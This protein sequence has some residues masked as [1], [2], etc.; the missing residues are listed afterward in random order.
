MFRQT[1]PQL[2]LQT[3]TGTF[4][5]T[6]PVKGL[7]LVLAQSYLWITGSLGDPGLWQVISAQSSP[8]RPRMVFPEIALRTLW[9][10]QLHSDNITH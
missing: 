4:P 6:L 7:N 9:T 10:P 3:G 5:L 1:L 2:Y 8:A